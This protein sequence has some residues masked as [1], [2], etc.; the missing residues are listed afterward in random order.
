MAKFKVFADFLGLTVSAH[1]DQIR[2]NCCVSV[3]CLN[4]ERDSNVI[5]PLLS[6]C[7]LSKMQLNRCAIVVLC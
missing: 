3:V 1:I 4:D 5:Q 6:S 2:P 7:H